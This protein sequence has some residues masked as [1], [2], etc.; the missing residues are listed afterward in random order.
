MSCSGCTAGYLAAFCAGSSTSSSRPVTSKV[1]VCTL[2]ANAACTWHQGILQYQL[3]HREGQRQ[4]SNDDCDFAALHEM[5][6]LQP[7]LSNAV[8]ALHAQTSSE[9]TV[10]QGFAGHNVPLSVIH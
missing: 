7:V 1:Q 5:L 9:A 8:Y 3:G 4:M 2:S 6:C 10:V